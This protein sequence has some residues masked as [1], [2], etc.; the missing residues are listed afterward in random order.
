MSIAIYK[1]NNDLYHIVDPYYGGIWEAEESSI[2]IFLRVLEEMKKQNVKDLKKLNISEGM[3]LEF[4]KELWLEMIDFIKENGISIFTQFDPRR[5]YDNLDSYG[6]GI[7][8]TPMTIIEINR[9]CNYN[10]PWCYLDNMIQ[11]EDVLSIEQMEER[12]VDPLLK[13]GA[14]Y[15]AITGG[16]P[17]VT[18]DRTLEFIKRIKDKTIKEF[19]YTPYILLFT[20]G[21]KLK[22]YAE[23]YKEA[24]VTIVQVSL[25]SPDEA[26]EVGLRR[27]PKGINS[28]KEAVEGIKKCKELGLEVILNSVIT[29]DVG[30][31]SNVDNIPKIYKLAK[32]LKVDTLD[33]NLAC[34]SGQAKKNNIVFS[35]E[36]YLKIKKYVQDNKFKEDEKINE[37]LPVD[38]L[39]DHRDIRCGVGMLEFYVDYKGYTYPCNNLIHED[40][41]CT[42]R[43]ILEENIIDIWFTSE[44]LSV[45]REYEDN[46]INEECGSCE[47]RGF[48]IGSC[49][50]RG[51]HQYGM[52]KMDKKPEKCYKD[53]Y[54]V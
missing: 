28:Y 18:L 8:T 12:I 16:E 41:L 32:E 47:Y 44:K 17:S 1:V 42:P 51:W 2:K 20:N 24:G 7:I 34:P 14:N 5:I 49:F 27:P 39:E 45:F 4:H 13:A 52:L 43:T 29:S 46:N 30:Y 36:E 53:V 6:K 21:H 40:M 3:L 37:D 50:A 19:G 31:G 38:E 22:E 15:W 35:K 48:C 9:V 25:S 10:C 23:L 11:D 33:I 26:Q 54:E